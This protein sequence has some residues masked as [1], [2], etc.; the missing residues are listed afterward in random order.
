MAEI[1]D[2]RSMLTQLTIALPRVPI[3]EPKPS[4]IINVKSGRNITA[5]N[6]FI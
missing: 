4:M 5:T 2:A 3:T 1:T 6:I